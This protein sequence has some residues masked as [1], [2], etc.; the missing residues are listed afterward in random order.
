MSFFSQL[1]RLW[2]TEDKTGVSEE[3]K[4]RIYNLHTEAEVLFYIDDVYQESNERVITVV[5]EWVKG[6]LE[7]KSIC[8]FLDCEGLPMREGKI[9][10]SKEEAISHSKFLRDELKNILKIRVLDGSLEDVQAAQMLIKSDF[11][12]GD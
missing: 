11:K 2:K 12:G 9:L 10:A 7:K 8:T 1:K 3:T 4:R 5:G 6:N